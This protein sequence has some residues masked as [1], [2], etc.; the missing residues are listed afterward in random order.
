[1]PRPLRSAIRLRTLIIAPLLVL[2]AFAVADDARSDHWGPLHLLEGTWRGAVVGELGEGTG[3]RRYEFLFDGTYL[4]TRHASVRLPQDKSPQ[5]D[6]HRELTVFSYDRERDK[7]VLR[8][9]NVEGYVL[10]YDCDATQRRVICT[11]TRV[12]SGAGMRARMTLEIE[13]AYRFEE[14]FE[15]AG[16]GDE[17]T[18]YLTVQWVR[19]PYI[20]H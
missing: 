12:E 11:S 10:E 8:E 19:E 5:G 15:L 1:M 14:K 3:I 4:M 9:F 18:H 2:P 6:H 13:D 20:E 7:L 16:P 17:L